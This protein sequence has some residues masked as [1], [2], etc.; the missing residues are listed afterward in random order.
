MATKSHDH[1]AVSMTKRYDAILDAA[2]DAFAKNGFS[3]TG[4]RE[5]AKIA[6][7][8]QPTINYHFKTKEK[9]FEAIVKR[10]AERS[11]QARIERLAKRLAAP[12]PTALEDIVRI[13][14]EVYNMPPDKISEEEETYNRFIAKFGY[15]DS[16]D[17]RRI[18]L[19]AFDEM[20]DYFIMAIQCAEDG[21][22]RQTATWAYLYSLPTGIYS[23]AHERRF[24]GLA[25][26]DPNDPAAHY[27][28]DDVIDFVCAGMRSLKRSG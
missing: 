7:V 12:E 6:R 22:D 5:I 21:F 8:A 16:E 24:A 25:G 28:F 10:G 15:G 2:L 9:L 23:V 14:F 1:Y 18:V 3:G 4:L 19:S 17:A 26:V 13:L 20:A 27:S 11:T